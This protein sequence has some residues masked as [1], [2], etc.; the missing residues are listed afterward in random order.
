MKC[1]ACEHENVKGAHFCANC[2]AV[3]PGEV[4]EGRGLVGQT[5]GGRFRIMR[6]LGEGG[7]GVVYEAEQPMGST[8]RRVAVKTLHAHLSH[9]PSVSARFHRECG[10]VAQL[11]HPNTI[12]VYDFGTTPDGTLYIAMEFVHGTSLMDEI[13]KHGVL[14]PDRTLKILR[15]IAGSLAEAHQQGIIHRDLKPENVVLTERAGEKDVVKLLD[16]GIA[17]RTESADAAKEQKLTQQGMVLGTP[18]YMSP[19]Q[20]TGKALDARSDIYSLGVM[21]YEMLTGRLPFQADTP[22]QW[23]T[24]HMMSQPMPFEANPS[25]S[26]IPES[27]R[28]AV[29]RSLAKDRVDRQA[30]VA[31]FLKELTG[32]SVAPVAAGGGTGTSM[33]EAAPDFGASAGEVGTARTAAMPAAS[34][35]AVGMSM[36]SVPGVPQAPPRPSSSGGGK[37]LVF[38][39]GGVAAVLLIG[40]L[41]VAAQS[42]K[43]SAA[44]APPPPEPAE[45]PK[46]VATVEPEVVADPTP[47]EPEEPSPAAD[48]TPPPR[49]PAPK[50]PAKPAGTTPATTPAAQPTAEPAKPE[51]APKPTPAPQPAPAPAPAGGDTCAACISAAN[52]GNFSAAASA[53]QSCSN[54]DQKNRCKS[55]VRARAPAAARTAAFNCNCAQAKAIAAA[56]NGIGAGSPALTTA[57]ATC[58]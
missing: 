36:G 52:S 58:N 35:P 4:Q 30:T 12:K 8:V 47:E 45:P 16:F 19:E 26:A 15:Q 14:P 6:V 10:T 22:W 11:E 18:P 39:L 27:M 51:P 5:I 40:I 2:G 34:G 28:A 23:A 41:V 33:M 46:P 9:D 24:E 20:F 55:V 57:I 29:M 25:S 44:D 32:E 13:H 3:L 42:M 37:G 17:A 48:P 50:A 56:A 43:P 31:E 21:A 54:A 49:A 53:Y 38:G 7:M 1:E